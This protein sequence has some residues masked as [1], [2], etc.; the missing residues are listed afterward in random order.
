MN[1]TIT[2]LRLSMIPAFTTLLNL[3]LYSAIP[4]IALTSGGIH[5]SLHTKQPFSLRVQE[6]HGCKYQTDFM[7][8]RHDIDSTFEGKIVYIQCPPLDQSGNKKSWMQQ[9]H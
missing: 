9:Y 4:L 5:I 8:S 7:Q 1:Q 6:V 3:C 2:Q